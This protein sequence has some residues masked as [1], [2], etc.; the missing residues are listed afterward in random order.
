M[1]LKC[2]LIILFLF[3]F[4]DY[5]QNIQERDQQVRNTMDEN[6]KKVKVIVKNEK[7]ALILIIM[8]CRYQKENSP[9]RPGIKKLLPEVG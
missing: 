1:F 8:I 9:P 7:S 4:D 3:Q 5:E 2:L 6:I